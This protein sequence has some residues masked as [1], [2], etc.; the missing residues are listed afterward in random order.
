MLCFLSLQSKPAKVVHFPVNILALRT[1]HKY[2]RMD[3]F[4]EDNFIVDGE[5]S[6]ENSDESGEDIGNSPVVKVSLY[7]TSA[8]GNGNIVLNGLP[9]PE[10]PVEKKMRKGARRKKLEECSREWVVA[11]DSNTENAA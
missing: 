2:E 11:I 1:V 4:E 5:D 8:E 6:R 10:S 7:S 3:S 9:S